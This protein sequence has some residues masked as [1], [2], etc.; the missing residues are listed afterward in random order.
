M[1]ASIICVDTLVRCFPSKRDFRIEQSGVFL[2]C[3]LSLSFGVMVWESTLTFVCKPL[4]SVQLFS[5]LV[6]ILPSSKSYLNKA[7]FSAPSAE[8]I[9]LGCFI[10]GFVG[11]QVVSR[12]L[13]R[14]IPSHVV[15]CDHTHA[16]TPSEGQSNRHSRTHSHSTHDQSRRHSRG[17]K[18]WADGSSKMAETTPLLNA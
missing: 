13:H 1:G 2:A 18:P 12:F 4:M 15:D 16:G 7:G 10:S 5:A 8:W 17:V 6:G 9:R 14:F 11:I 3:S